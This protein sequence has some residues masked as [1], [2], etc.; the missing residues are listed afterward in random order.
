MDLD[1]EFWMLREN[2]FDCF[3]EDGKVCLMGALIETHGGS[4]CFASV[5]DSQDAESISMEIN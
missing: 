5:F 2:L 1:Q 4:P 3:I